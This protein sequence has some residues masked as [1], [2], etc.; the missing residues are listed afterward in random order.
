M[1]KV[2]KI[3]RLNPISV[4][5]PVGNY[6]HVTIVPQNANWYTFSGQIGTDTN[7]VIPQSFN[8]QVNNTFENIAKLLDSQGLLFEDVIKVNIW[9]IKEIDW[10]YF[11]AIWK[12]YF[13]KQDPSM[14][15]AYITALGLPEISLEIEVWAA[16]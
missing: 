2:Q 10:E 6:S 3:T 14:T 11:D 7:G 4:A 15:V 8:A 13:V 9:S 12:K 1:T 5:H 16:K